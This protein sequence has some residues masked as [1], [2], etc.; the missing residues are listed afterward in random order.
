MENELQDTLVGEFDPQALALVARR[1]LRGGRNSK[2]VVYEI[3]HYKPSEVTLEAAKAAYNE[4]YDRW[5]SADSVTRRIRDSRSIFQG[6]VPP[7]DGKFVHV[8]TQVESDLDGLYE[9]TH[10]SGYGQNK[11]NFI[12][13]TNHPRIRGLRVGDLICDDSGNWYM[14]EEDDFLQ[15]QPPRRARRVAQPRPE[16]PARESA[17]GFTRGPTPPA[18]ADASS[19]ATGY[20]SLDDDTGDYLQQYIR[21][22]RK[23]NS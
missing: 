21:S 20:Y 9:E 16:R 17:S 6:S 1:P 23:S 11:N 8:A 10:Q 13:H 7:E 15:V 18:P 22:R 2:R 5:E 14:V 4:W 3:Y 12:N 19:P